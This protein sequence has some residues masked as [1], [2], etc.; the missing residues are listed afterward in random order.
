MLTGRQSETVEM[1]GQRII[2]YH[3]SHHG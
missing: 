2:T 3:V 1:F